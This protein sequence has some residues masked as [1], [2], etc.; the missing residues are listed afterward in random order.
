[1]LKKLTIGQQEEILEAAVKTFGSKGFDA[2]KISEIA[3][4]ASVS[5]GVIYK[6]YEDKQALFD[7]CIGHS[8]EILDNTFTRVYDLGGSLED[9]IR[10][11]IKANIDFARTH[12]DYIR[13]YHMVT[14]GV[15][16]ES[17]KDI[18]QRIESNSSSIYSNLIS[19]AKS[20]GVVR[21]DLTPADFAFFFDDLM[22]MLHFSY[23]CEYYEE[24][25]RIYC[26]ENITD[27]KYDSHVE[28]E[29]MKF[30][31]GALG[32]KSGETK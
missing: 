22:M 14:M 7:A 32:L 8:M 11:L 13:M 4:E 30:I 31:S 17:T 1:M 29:L 18:A 26:G 28:D 25:M 16:P 2:A 21:S 3:R 19:K 6:Y 10:N 15:G 5:V 12:P 20:D 27:K 24:R 23:T 9:M